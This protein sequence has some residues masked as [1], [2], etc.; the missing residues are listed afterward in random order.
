MEAF[1]LKTL[2][3]LKKESPRRFKELRDVCDE[4]IGKGLALS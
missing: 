2:R 1:V 4:M 3:R